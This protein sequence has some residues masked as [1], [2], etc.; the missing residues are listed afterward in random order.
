MVAAEGAAAGALPVVAR[1]SSLAEVAEALEGAI[2]RPG[3]LS[4]EPGPGATRR[5]AE[6]L[7][8]LLAEARGERAE[9]ARDVRGHVAA[10]WTWERTAERLLA[11]AT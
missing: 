3:A 5:L 1:H 6:R 2:G 8:S 4:F 11:V 7:S 9:Q 10:E